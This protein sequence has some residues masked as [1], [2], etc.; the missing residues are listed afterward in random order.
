M[1]ITLAILRM[2]SRC[3]NRNIVECKLILESEKIYIVISFNRNIVEC[4]LEGTLPGSRG[5][6]V[7]IETLWNVNLYGKVCVFTG[8]LRF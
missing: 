7:L 2:Y 4:K 1:W 5:F 3:F 6:G 8:A